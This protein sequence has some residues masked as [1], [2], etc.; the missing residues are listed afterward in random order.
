[1]L[2]QVN[3]EKNVLLLTTKK[4]DSKLISK[5]K[6]FKNNFL[7]L[8]MPII[9]LFE[10]KPTKNDIFR[11]IE[12]G[13]DDYIILPCEKEV[14]DARIDMNVCRSQ[15]YLDVNP[16]T[17]LPG[18]KTISKIIKKNCNNKKAQLYVDICNFKSYN[19]KYGFEKGDKIICKVASFLVD[20]V[21]RYGGEKDF[22]GHIGGDDFIIVTEKSRLSFLR[23]II[24]KEAVNSIKEVKVSVNKKG[25]KNV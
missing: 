13:I 15:H 10:N 23:K 24:E 4:I 5:I 3:K 19:D 8:H 6:R 7:T 14:I 21:K 22:L 25:A 17:K 12:A 16:L 2:T 11:V 20:I 9:I 18:N 1:M